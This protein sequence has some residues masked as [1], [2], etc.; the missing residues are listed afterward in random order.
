MRALPDSQQIWLRL[1]LRTSVYI[2]LFDFD[3]EN[4]ANRT[5][6]VRAVILDVHAHCNKL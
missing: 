4:L 1:A 2:L 3:A 5:D 6:L